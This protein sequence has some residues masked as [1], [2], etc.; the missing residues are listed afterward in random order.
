MRTRRSPRNQNILF[1][2][3]FKPKPVTSVELV[4]SLREVLQSL[5]AH[6]DDDAKRLNLERDEVCPCNQNEVARAKTLIQRFEA[7]LAHS[8]HR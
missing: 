2:A 6:L 5:E 3:L 7:N 8:H 4:R 1:N